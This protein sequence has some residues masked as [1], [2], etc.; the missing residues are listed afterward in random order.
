[1]RTLLGEI[2]QKRRKVIAV[3]LVCSILL[4]LRVCIKSA[5][6]KRQA[7]RR[8]TKRAA[9]FLS[10]RRILLAERDLNTGN[11]TAPRQIIILQKR[12]S[13]AKNIKRRCQINEKAPRKCKISRLRHRKAAKKAH[14]AVK[15]R[16]E[17]NTSAGSH[18]KAKRVHQSEISAL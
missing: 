2:R 18:L 8:G 14:L 4:R 10:K 6:R 12:I 15:F 9:A 7:Q 11:H 1:M 16:K 3:G 5:A 17:L 13:C